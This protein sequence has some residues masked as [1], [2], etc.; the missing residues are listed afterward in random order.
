[1]AWHVSLLLHLASALQYDAITKLQRHC[2]VF[3]PMSL[4]GGREY[5][6]RNLCGIVGSAVWNDSP[7]WLLCLLRSNTHG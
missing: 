4:G 7:L 3:L 1:M 2:L 6:R 5:R